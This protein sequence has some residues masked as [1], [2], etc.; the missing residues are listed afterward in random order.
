MKEV[1][2]K[3]PCGCGQ[4][5]DNHE[6]AGTHDT[7]IVFCPLHQAAEDLLSACQAK[8]VETHF[9]F[10]ID[11]VEVLRRAANL[12]HGPMQRA[13]IEMGD[14]M[15]AAIAKATVAARL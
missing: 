1:F 9:G 14:R 11:G 12:L 3:E 10:G 8:Y 7:H 15:E 5:F 2:R 4:A 6:L 13:L